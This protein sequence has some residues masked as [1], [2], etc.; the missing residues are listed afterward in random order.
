MGSED[1]E[2]VVG[3]LGVG[4]H[5]EGVVAGEATASLEWIEHGGDRMQHSSLQR[6]DR[7]LHP[8]LVYN[9]ACASEGGRRG[10]PLLQR[11]HTAASP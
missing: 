11:V 3:Q 2:S 9:D 4:G 5:H 1:G 8:D 10:P 7:R 6:G